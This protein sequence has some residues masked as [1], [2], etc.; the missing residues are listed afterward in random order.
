MESTKD[1]S[2]DSFDNDFS[3]VSL[4]KEKVR[5][6][7]FHGWNNKS[8][9][10]S[11]LA[12]SGFRYLYFSDHVK[13]MFCGIE[14]CNWDD[15]DDVM[16]EHQTFSPLCRLLCREK[17]KNEPIDV[18]DLDRKLPPQ[19]RD[20]CGIGRMPMNTVSEGTVS[21]REIERL[22]HEKI[23]QYLMKYGYRIVKTETD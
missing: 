12:Q 8:V 10:P 15:G 5:L 20:E 6:N 23:R 22:E 1:D 17:T 4:Y 3:F 14:I 16:K 7:T 2:K 9:K 13:C 18:E 11:D 19:S 21:A